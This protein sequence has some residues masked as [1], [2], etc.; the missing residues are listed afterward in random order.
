MRQW[1]FMAATTLA[2]ATEC[3]GVAVVSDVGLIK[4]DGPIG[5]ATA[6]YIARAVEQSA[7]H[8][9]ECL[10]IQ[11][12]TP[13]G[14][15]DSTKAIIQTFYS[16]KVPIVVYVAPAPAIAGSAGVFI[17]MAADVAV[18][19]PHTSIG[20]AH[21]VNIG[22]SGNVEKTD[23]VMKQKQENALSSMIESIADKRHRNAEWAKA[24][25][26]ESVAI[27]A[28]TALK[29]NVV[30]LIAADLPDLL[31][32]LDGRKVGERTLHTAN[33]AITE[34]PMNA[35]EKFLG[36]FLRPEM[37]F[38][39][40]LVVIYGIIGE[41][42]NP[43]TILPGVAGAIALILVL[44]MSAVLPINWAGLALIALAV[45]LFIGDIYATT[46]GVLTVGGIVSFFLGALMLFD[47]ADPTFRLSLGL[48]IP[49]T[50]VTAL[51]FLFI[52][53]AGLR[54]QS[55]P[56]RVGRETMLG[57]VVPAL[58]AIDAAGGK[59]FIEGELWNAVSE[60]AVAKDQPVEIAGIEGLTL[61][62]KPKT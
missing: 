40:M 57:Q 61:K 56:V 41:L 46:H 27:T 32:Q 13:G 33:L 59:V 36:M 44:C 8:G 47:R 58:T 51:F 22:A 54:A 1:I 53:A 52:V 38:V 18:M 17:T 50:V 4:I 45:A 25:V 11:L 3:L 48:I 55:L 30:D 29:S 20:A 37:M 31:N 28:E 19:A 21:P 6:S 9:D 42:S 14:L 7:A 62:V 5:P 26:R 23:D 24:A 35:R 60:T 39:L 2:F 49:A 15:V 16:S 43:G 10:V 12:D 34:I